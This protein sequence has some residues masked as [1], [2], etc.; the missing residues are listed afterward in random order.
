M[1]GLLLFSPSCNMLNVF[2]PMR[3]PRCV[4]RHAGLSLRR[5]R[6]SH[7]CVLVCTG[8]GRHAALFT[9]PEYGWAQ[10]RSFAI[11]KPA[12]G[13]TVVATA[14]AARTGSPEEGTVRACGGRCHPSADY[15]AARRALMDMCSACS[16]GSTLTRGCKFLTSYCCILRFKRMI[17]RW[18]CRIVNDST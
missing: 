1:S 11:W 18:F 7:G 2:K 16:L 12:T 8:D 10:R 14:T 17:L 5:R 13:I 15:V 9:R 3:V 6:C 4:Q